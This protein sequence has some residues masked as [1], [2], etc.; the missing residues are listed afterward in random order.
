MKFRWLGN[1]C[2]ELIG[3]KHVLIDPNYVV[4]PERDPDYVLITHEHPD[5]FSEKAKRLN[6][7]F[8]APSVALETFR[9]KGKAVK[10][11]QAIDHIE[12][13]ESFCYKS[14][15]SVGY[16]IKEKLRVLHLG[17]SFKAPEVKTDVLFVPI[18]REYHGEI[19]EM[20][21]KCKAKHVF[22]IHFSP[23]EKRDLAVE[24]VSKLREKAVK[25]ELMEI[26]EWIKDED[27]EI[28]RR[29]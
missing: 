4:G 2:I 8:Y 14:K 16:L 23:E 11:G 12:V 1:S 22:P 19:I 29:P 27:L 20:A 24:L 13:V 17:D 6:S 15:E 3:E 25:S 28:V 26:G 5:H 7:V 9:I 21:L 18:F 10:P